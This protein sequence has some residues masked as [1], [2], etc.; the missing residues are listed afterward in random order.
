MKTP[1]LALSSL[2]LKTNQKPKQTTKEAGNHQDHP[3]DLMNQDFLLKLE[4]D[5]LKCMLNN[6]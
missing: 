6:A 5:S 3:K 2:A 4:K 1:T